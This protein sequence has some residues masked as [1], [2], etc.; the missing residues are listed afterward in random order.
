MSW[1]FWQSTI[2]PTFQTISL[3]QTFSTFFFSDTKKTFSNLTIFKF[4][5]F[6]QFSNLTK[7]VGRTRTLRVRLVTRLSTRIWVSSNRGVTT[8]SRWDTFSCTS[9]GGPCHGK[10]G[11]S[12]CEKFWRFFHWGGWV[13]R[14]IDLCVHVFLL[15]FLGDPSHVNKKNGQKLREPILTILSQFFLSSSDWVQKKLFSMSDGY[16]II[17]LYIYSV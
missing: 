15:V 14:L 1:K 4:D 7:F 5:N 3:T 9:W 6:D 13:R 10:V 12:N 16:S 2:E 17:Y 11:G 8:S